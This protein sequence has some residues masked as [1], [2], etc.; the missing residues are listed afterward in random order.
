MEASV[1]RRIAAVFLF[2]TVLVFSASTPT[3]AQSYDTN[4]GIGYDV[5]THVFDETS[6]A[7]VNIDLTHFFRD[8]GTSKIGVG[9]SVDFIHFDFDTLKE[10]EGFVAIRGKAV[11]SMNAMPFGRFG[12][13]A[14]SSGGSTDMLIN[15]GGG[16]DF[17]PKRTW[18]V[19]I[20]VMLD[21]KRIFFEDDGANLVRLS[22]G[23]VIP[24]ARR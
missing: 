11:G 9:G 24:L 4:L 5:F 7:G 16:V 13:G 1:K 8:F 22:A 2:A 23:V 19:M 17:L 10:Y 3:F 12:I 18:P 15:F 21:Y 20:R 6:A 14:D